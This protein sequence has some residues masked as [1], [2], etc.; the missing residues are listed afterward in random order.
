M[1]RSQESTI[2]ANKEKLVVCSWIRKS[3]KLPFNLSQHKCL[4]RLSIFATVHET[5]NGPVV[6]FD[7]ALPAIKNLIETAPPIQDVIL[8]L[9]W[10]DPTP[11]SLGRFDYSL[12]FPNTSRIHLSIS[13][14][15]DGDSISPASILE[16]LAENEGLM[17][18]V[19]RDVVIL[20]P[21][22]TAPSPDDDDSYS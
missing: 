7:G 14:D 13:G 4:K 10:V 16:T 8:H 6:A 9:H 12:L 15:I 3:Q 18:L 21:R 20:K 5:K 2:F 22:S 19:K 1:T 17:D 11:G